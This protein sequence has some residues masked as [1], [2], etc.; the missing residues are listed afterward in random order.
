MQQTGA[1]PAVEDFAAM[2]A[3]LDERDVRRAVKW[4]QRSGGLLPMPPQAGDLLA[5]R[6]A[7]RRR[8]V[9]PWAV[10]VTVILVG[11]LFWPTS[12]L[13]TDSE[14][15]LVSQARLGLPL[16][17]GVLALSSW[18]LQV[19]QQRAERRIAAALPARVGRSTA[20]PLQV[21][22]G[23]RR[24][25]AGLVAVVVMLVLNLVL[26]VVTPGWSAVVPLIA[27]ALAAAS[28]SA[29]VRRAM[30]REP[31]AFDGFSLAVDE[32][33]RSDDTLQAFQPVTT[34]LFVSSASPAMLAP[35]VPDWFLACL[36]AG[37]TITMI[38][39]FLAI[40][41]RPWDNPQAARWT[42][43]VLAQDHSS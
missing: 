6:L 39:L 40:T 3:V 9:L 21:L 10:S 24:L 16:L 5:V 26:I 12:D 8:M 33:L 22:V 14:T 20:P 23:R 7:A 30:A 4:L 15:G 42:A 36:A 43:P 28:A 17:V 2:T 29:A 34:M 38:S 27:W 41:D 19:L 18:P 13:F 37:W 25:W 35:A 32:R 1:G 31:I 11:Y